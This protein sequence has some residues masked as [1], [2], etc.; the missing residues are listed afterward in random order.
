MLHIHNWN[1]IDAASVPLY[2]TIHFVSSFSDMLVKKKTFDCN[3][4]SPS[5]AVSEFLLL[6]SEKITELYFGRTC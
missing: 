4:R 5:V 2:S 6:S 1:F 3:L